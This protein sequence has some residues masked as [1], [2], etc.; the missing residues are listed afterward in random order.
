[1]KYVLVTGSNGGMGES[2]VQL[3]KN[4]G[5]YVFALDLKKGRDEENVMN[6]ECDVTNEDSIKCAFEQINK[7]T[8]ELYGIIHFIGIYKMN[9]LVEIEKSDFEQIFKI[10]VFGAYLINK[11]FLPLLNKNSRIIITTSELAT[12][13]PLPFTGL[14]GITKST[15]DKYAFSLKMELQL[16]GIYVSVL[17]AGAVNTKML[18]V[19]T[20]ELGSFC[21]NTKLYSCNADR[22][23]KIVNNVETKN[24]EPFKLS[25]KVVKILNKKHPKFA[26]SINRNILL[27]LLN[28][29]PQKMQFWIIKKVLK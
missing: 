4:K 9:S 1:M 11:I 26:Y 13:D 14:Y 28:I 29:L 15:L 6:I 24:I 25:K 8:P 10:N 20:S 16:L 17:R 3:L 22:F 18:G 27:K 2:T 19:S 21:N 23:K 5:Y 7:V 12:L